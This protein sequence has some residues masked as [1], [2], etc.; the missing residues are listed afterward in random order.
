MGTTYYTPPAPRRGQS[1]FLAT[2][3]YEAT[4]PGYSYSLALT[5]AELVRRGINFEL[6]IMEGNCHVDDGR[7]NLV[8]QFLNG[9][10]TDMLFIDSDLR[11]A[12]DNVLKI[13]AH[14]EDLI[15]GAYPF[16][17]N[18]GGYPIGRI[19]NARPDGMLEV[20]YAP[21]GFMRIRREVFTKL[22][23]SQSRHGTENP[24]SVYFERRFNGKTRDGGDVTF[25]RKWIAA[26]GK[27]MVDPRLGFEHIGET[28]WSGK[29]I[30]YLAKEENRAKHYDVGVDASAGQPPIAA[31]IVSSNVP[32][33]L[34]AIR[35]GDPS[36][37]AFKRLADAYGN[38]PW[39]ATYEYLEMAYRMA[40]NLPLDA[41]ILECGSGISTVVL[42]ATGRPLTVVEENPEWAEATQKLLTECELDARILCA[43]VDG[44][45]Y[46]AK[47]A[48]KDYQ[49][50]LL[51][52]DG[53]RR[54]KDINHPEPRE[55]LNRNWP[56]SSEARLAGVVTRDVAMIVD[57][58]KSMTGMGEWIQCGT[59]RQFVA[60]RLNVA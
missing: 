35:N 1:V 9:N 26:G 10:C 27:V 59:E 36:L 2:P 48:L 11:W 60:G 16:K 4:K 22:Y 18:A 39:A 21:T 49:A 6:G 8:R 24:T 15:C 19:L 32:D 40:M 7:N 41:K 3:A 25:C 44:D 58:M 30:D 29:F 14:N 34:K 53:P 12:A 50:D 55:G 33:I 51:V 23:P 52:I 57:D 28:R 46:A 37:D 38:K 43:P 17:S 47:D 20:S 45:W 54:R 13:L 5:T 56:I 31:D 42:A